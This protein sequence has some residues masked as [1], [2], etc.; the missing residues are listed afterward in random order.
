M[1]NA[2]FYK[3]EIESIGASL[4][5]S[6]L[7]VYVLAGAL[8]NLVPGYFSRHTIDVMVDQ[9]KEILKM[10]NALQEGTTVDD[11]VTAVFMKGSMH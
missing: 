2:T 6:R 4:Q 5:Q 3:D 1:N 10:L 7:A 8:L 9:E 11:L